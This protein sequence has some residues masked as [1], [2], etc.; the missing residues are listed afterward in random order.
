VALSLLAS[1]NTRAALTYEPGGTLRPI[2]LKAGVPLE[3]EITGLAPDRSYEYTIASDRPLASGCF[4]TARP[5]GGPF[6]FDV[7]ADSHLDS[8]SDPRVYANTLANIVADRPDFLI[9]LGDTF[10]T[11]KYQ[12]YREAAQQYL[13][14]RYYLGLAGRTM[15]VF[16]ALGNHDGEAGWPFRDGD[17]TKWASAERQRYFPPVRPND[18][19]TAGPARNVYHAWTWGDALFIVLDPFTET[20]AKPRADDDGWAWTLGRAQYDW[21][22]ATLEASRAANTFVF[23]HHLVGGGT[24]EARGGAEASRFFEW[25]G[26]NLDG[27]QGFE[28]HRPGWPTPIH[29]LLVAHGVSVVFH[30]HDHL[31][32]RQERGGLAYQEVPQPSQARGD[33][34]ASAKGYGY[35]SGTIL[36]SSGHVRV[37]VSVAGATVEYVKARLTGANAEVVD[38]YVLE[39]AR[40]QP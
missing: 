24:R 38:R 20:R 31:Y 8:N 19:Y 35:L 16:L 17:V 40:R 3:V 5:A 37:A 30:G 33:S 14:Q 22:R 39:P 9:D 27:T 12:A 4:R 18:F 26:A 13:A 15:P 25:G 2:D 23:I 32:A 11:E 21:L 10:M 6:T 29:D 1:R 28:A 36:G 34:T 7:Q